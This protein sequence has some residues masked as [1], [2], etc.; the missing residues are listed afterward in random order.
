MYRCRT[1]PRP[2]CERFLHGERLRQTARLQHD[3]G[4]RPHRGAL[5]HGVV[6][7]YA[8]GTGGRRGKA[9]HN[10]QR[11]GL[12]RA[13]RAQEPEGFS[14]CN[15]QAYPVHRGEVVVLPVEVMNF[16]GWFCCVHGSNFS[17]GQRPL[18]EAYVSDLHDKSHRS[19]HTAQKAS[20]FTSESHPDKLQHSYQPGGCRVCPEIQNRMNYAARGNRESRPRRGP[21]HR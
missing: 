9:L 4:V 2:H 19:S 18:V 1:R 14:A 10:F 12:A 13:V 8:H 7:Q 11:G 17:V 21:L 15:A 16:D 6:S 5:G 20:Q 3:A